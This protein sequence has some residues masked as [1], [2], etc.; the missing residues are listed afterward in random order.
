M[1][2]SGA[3][4]WAP[5]NAASRRTPLPFAGAGEFLDLPDDQ[6]LLKAPEAIDEHR[7]FEM[8]HL[9]LEAARQQSRCFDDVFR[10]FTSEPFDDHARGTSQ[11]R[12]EAGHAETAFL[13]E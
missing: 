5:Q 13:F 3:P 11:R 9:E 4:G 10:A 6:I 12:V 7:S 2:R 8:I 1:K